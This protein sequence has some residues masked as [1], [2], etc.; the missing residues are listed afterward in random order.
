MPFWEKATR[1]KTYA[2][3]PSPRGDSPFP[4]ETFRPYPDWINNSVNELRLKIKQFADDL[5]AEYVAFD[6]LKDNENNVAAV[7][8][9]RLRVLELYDNIDKHVTELLSWREKIDS[10]GTVFFLMKMQMLM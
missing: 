4:L 10:N 6:G 1:N 7:K 2:A 5:I 8:T 3:Q 9:V